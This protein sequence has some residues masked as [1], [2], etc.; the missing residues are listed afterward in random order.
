MLGTKPGRIHHPPSGCAFLNIRDDAIP[1]VPQC[2]RILEPQMG[3]ETDPQRAR[4]TA[5]ALE[6]RAEARER[7][8]VELNETAASLER[9]GQIEEAT[10]LRRA[11]NHLQ[12]R[13]LKERRRAAKL[14]CAAEQGRQLTESAVEET[15]MIDR[16]LA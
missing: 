12:T 15:R 8:I 5:A 11:A 7:A 4:S 14:R 1:R 3:S 10:R 13:M 9:S 2:I 16:E 6:T